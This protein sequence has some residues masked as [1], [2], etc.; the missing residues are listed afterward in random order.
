MSYDTNAP[1]IFKYGSTWLMF[2]A[3]PSKKPIEAR[4]EKSVDIIPGS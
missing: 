2:S 3:K 1:E 4:F